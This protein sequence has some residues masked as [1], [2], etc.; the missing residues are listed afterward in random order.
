MKVVVS[1]L[2]SKRSKN[3]TQ[4]YLN[5]N[6]IRLPIISNI[7]IV[8]SY[9]F[10][11]LHIVFEYVEYVNMTRTLDTPIILSIILKIDISHYQQAC[12]NKHDIISK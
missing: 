1:A 5:C 7:K 6:R 4:P 2:N 8:H 12:Y 10:S 11:H 3:N 9:W